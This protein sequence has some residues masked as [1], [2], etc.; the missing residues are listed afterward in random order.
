[1]SPKE[2]VAA[3]KKADEKTDALHAEIDALITERIRARAAEISG[4]PAGVLRKTLEAR[5]SCY[6]RCKALKNIASENDGL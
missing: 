3:L 2:Y 4:A 5:S 6:C 1:M